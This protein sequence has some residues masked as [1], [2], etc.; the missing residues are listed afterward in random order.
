[1]KSVISFSFNSTFRR[2]A[3]EMLK[4]RAIYS[5]LSAQFFS[6]GSVLK[7]ARKTAHATMFIKKC[8]KIQN[9]SWKLL[10]G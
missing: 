2:Q 8:Q 3:N 9:K 10:Y 7:S 6:E 5:F 1:M 4:D